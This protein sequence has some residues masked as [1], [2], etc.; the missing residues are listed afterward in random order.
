MKH[1]YLN[2]IITA[3]SGN[4]YYIS[5]S[6]KKVLFMHPILKHLVQLKEKGKLEEWLKEIESREFNEI[7]IDDG[8]Y[9][10]RDDI[11]YYSQYFHFL[12]KKNCFAEIEK[13]EMTPNIYSAADAKMSLANTTQVVFEVTESCNLKCKYCGYGEL[14]SGFDKRENRH[15]DL[16]VARGVFDYMIDLLESPL[17]RRYFKKIALSFYGGEPLLNMPFVKEM[18]RYAKLRELTHKGF[19]FSMTTNGVLLEKHMDFLAA[20]DFLLL[21]SLDGDKKN[22]AYRCFPDGRS[23]FEVVYNNVLKLRQKYPDYFHRSVNFISVIHDKN[24]NKEVCGFFN[25]EFEKTPVLI[26]VSPLGIKPEKKAEYDKLFNWKYSGITTKDI[27]MYKKDRAGRLKSPFPNTLFNFSRLY[28]GFVFRSYYNF[29]QKIVNPWYVCTGTCAP[30]EKKIFFTSN[31]KILPCER[32]T[33]ECS[34][35]TVDKNGVHLDFEEI[36]E[37]YNR[38]SRK[39]MNQ[40]NKCANSNSCLSCMFTLNI[41]DENPICSGRMNEKDFKKELSKQLSAFEEI[42]RYY[43][44]IMKD[45]QVN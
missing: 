30:F 42:P 34:L 8:I 23:S 24:S 25:K 3:E 26:E 20:N 22:N 6:T 14:Y 36:A 41:N 37:K 16:D 39:L 31:G 27:I 13:H 18:V 32:I 5:R 29:Q 17:N 43:S 21:V 2:D 11:H 4:N 15:F 38:Y 45:Y 44:E 1:K 40:C 12:E 28:S 7:K 35:G 10:S 33:Q 9:A 19:F